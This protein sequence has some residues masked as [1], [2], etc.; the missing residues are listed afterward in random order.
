M[1]INATLDVNVV[2]YE[3]ED[4]VAV[5]LE[6][7]APAAPTDVTRPQASLQVVL[8]RSGSMSGAPLEGAKKALAA[9]VRQ[10]EP[11]DNFG[12]VTFDNTA[13]VVV[14]AGPLTDK[15]GVVR[16]IEA[17]HA[18]GMT[19]LS[20]GYLRGLR[21]IRR[22]ATA[23]GTALVVSDGHVNE[24]IRDVDEFATITS[25][26]YA[27]GVVT[28]TLGYGRGYDETLLSAIAR[29]GSGN[30]FFADNPDAA[31]AAI[32]GEVEGLLNKTVQALSLTVK[33][34]PAVQFLRL[35][36][37]LPAHQIG[38][39]TVMIELGD[40][41]AQEAR[42]LLL[43]FKV[44]AMASLGL[45]K[46]ATLE[47]TYIEL[48]GL[49]EHTATLPISV[50]IVPGDEAAGRIPHPTVHSEVLFQEAQDTKRQASEAFES[51]DLDRG[52]HL[53]GQTKARLAMSM[54]VAPEPLKVEIQAELNEIDR[55]DA[56][57]VDMGA[58]YM[59]KVSRDSYHQMNR[60]RGRAP[61]PNH[62]GEGD[63]K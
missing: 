30:H 21:E 25:R 34:E 18:G 44:P 27:D 48:P 40:L 20:A 55:M 42:K 36:N 33:F 57:A 4:E 15:D 46:I 56:M 29:S 5:L 11:N 2:A 14:P 24:G 26:A 9:L 53:L 52:K 35:Y 6:L 12:L 31:G 10:L 23:G 47:L 32:A 1:K 45:A 16:Q 59:S 38:D 7:E 17:V 50:N 60:K 19:D 37:D 61:Q 58:V 43:K 8:D 22:V 51:G 39:G 13:Q 41:Y 3:A 54:Q 49:I 63:T 62:T 28:S